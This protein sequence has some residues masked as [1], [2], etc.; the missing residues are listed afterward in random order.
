M[1]SSSMASQSC[2]IRNG[3]LGISMLAVAVV[4]ILIGLVVSTDYMIVSS[5]PWLRLLQDLPYA[6]SGIV[7]LV[8]GLITLLI[9]HA[10][11]IWDKQ[12]S[13]LLVLIVFSLHTMALGIGPLNPLNIGIVLTF[14]AWLLYRFA[15]PDD[16]IQSPAFTSLT[17]LFIGCALLS[18]LGRSITDVI[19]G[20]FVLLPK[21][22]MV[23]MLIDIIRTRQDIKL[24]LRA[25]MVSSVIA[26]CIGI[27]QLLAYV[28][29][30]WELHL[31][32]PEAPLYI[33]VMGLPLLRASGLEH[34]P[35]GYALPLLVASILLVYHICYVVEG[36]KRISPTLLLS[37]VC[38]LA[39]LTFSFVRGHWISG[40]AT[41]LVLPIIARPHKTLQWIGILLLLAIITMPSGILIVAYQK[42]EEFTSTNVL[43]R[44]DLLQAGFEILA[45]H[46]LNGVGIG[47]FAPYSPTVERYPIHNSIMQVASEMGLP[48]LLTF[49]VILIYVPVRLL[50]SLGSAKDITAKHAL[51]SLL[52]GYVAL[53]IA[54]QSDPM[55]YSEFLWFY[56]A[57]VESATRCFSHESSPISK[58]PA[59]PQITGAL[60]GKP[61]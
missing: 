25:F 43:V 23:L 35:Q 44:L 6:L 1:I 29:L 11:R 12:F 34:T 4:G 39:G 32:E 53:F 37:L 59:T 56:L 8:A 30:H 18:A 13:I 26:G 21:L 57:L 28:F 22:V 46:P 42:M 14:A 20:L 7:V 40:V 48:G 27:V 55:A 58:T 5:T 24:I 31:M 9:Y 38:L 10:D 61:L 15:T 52:V 41:L 45:E 49:L 50:R 60:G 3:S 51:K 36:W 2:S 54:I 47:N 16:P 17:I 33:T 19:G